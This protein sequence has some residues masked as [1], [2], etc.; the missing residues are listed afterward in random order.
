MI[1]AGLVQIAVLT[2]VA[3]AILSAM[4]KLGNVISARKIQ[5]ADSANF[6]LKAVLAMPQAELAVRNAFVMSMKMYLLAFVIR[7]L[8]SVF[9]R[10]I[11]KDFIVINV[12]KVS[13]YLFVFPTIYL[14]LYIKKI[15]LVKN[16]ILR[17]WL[18]WKYQ[19]GS[20]E[21]IFIVI[22]KESPETYLI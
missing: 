21:R 20:K 17:I 19:N 5:V 15:C 7:R 12:L 13:F 8:V 14:N 4:P 18:S 10:I 22:N 16:L 3:T 9:A 11:H 1:W 6:V 2:A